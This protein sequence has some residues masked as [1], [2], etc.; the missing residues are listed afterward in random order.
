MSIQI[1]I[2]SHPRF[3]SHEYS[4]LGVYQGVYQLL[5]DGPAPSDAIRR[6]A[7]HRRSLDVLSL[8]SYRAHLHVGRIPSRLTPDYHDSTLAWS[9]WAVQKSFQKIAS[10]RVLLVPPVG[11][12]RNGAAVHFHA[13]I[14]STRAAP[15]PAFHSRRYRIPDSAIDHRLLADRRQETSR[16]GKNQA[17]A[18]RVL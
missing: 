3:I 15:A 7:E 18:C 13:L 4:A 16:H 12:Q 1:H 5:V 17:S 9:V 6:R 10:E 2:Q 14:A 11:R 8:I